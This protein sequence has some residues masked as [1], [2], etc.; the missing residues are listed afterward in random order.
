MRY[1]FSRKQQGIIAYITLV[2]MLCIFFQFG[3]TTEACAKELKTFGTMG[4]EASI[5]ME[6]HLGHGIGFQDDHAPWGFDNLI[7][8]TSPGHA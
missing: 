7:F 2:A 3:F 8:E 1:Y 5:D 4:K 6:L